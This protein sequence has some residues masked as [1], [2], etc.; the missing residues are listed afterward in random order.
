MAGNAESRPAK[1]LSV[2]AATEPIPT[3]LAPPPRTGRIVAAPG[4]GPQ[5]QNLHSIPP[6]P[7]FVTRFPAVDTAQFQTVTPEETVPERS[8][9]SPGVVVSLVASVAVL[10]AFGWY[11]MHGTEGFK[12][13]AIKSF[14]QQWTAEPPVPEED[15]P[16]ITPIPLVPTSGEPESLATVEPASSKKADQV[17]LSDLLKDE[18][19]GAADGESTQLR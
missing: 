16:F 7:H 10:C 5:L 13:D 2:R 1:R 15:L 11:E 14:V 8:L 17:M 12:W 9:A 6:Q 4:T 19:H 18:P 3:P